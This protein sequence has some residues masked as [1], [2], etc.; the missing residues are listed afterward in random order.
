MTI[1]P[2]PDDFPPFACP[3]HKMALGPRLRCL[4]CDRQYPDVN[5]VPVLI[6]DAN[7]VFAIDDYLSSETAYDGASGYAGHLDQRRGIRQAY[8]RL[9]HRLLETDLAVRSFSIEDAM[10]AVQAARPQ[11][12][13]LVIGAG[14]TRFV[15]RVLYTDVAFGKNVNC[16]ADAHDLPFEDGSFDACFAVAVLEH[17]A[18]PQR[19]VS[20]VARVLKPGG[21]VFAETPFMQPVHMGAYDF[22]RFTF[23][24]HRRL[25]RSFDEVCSGMAGGP[26]T[27]AAQ[28]LRYALTSVSDRASI[29]KWL[30][31][32]S[33]VL[34]IPIRLLER[35]SRRTLS[36]YDSASG[37]YFFGR[38]RPTPISD[39]EMLRF[40]RGG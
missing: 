18:D 35:L 11:A 30:R 6:N 26:A 24:G 25:F 29:R 38:L 7:S 3:V 10:R 5:G 1:E 34:T 8:R 20:E 23:L 13:V 15:G 14:D 33:I 19:C 17:V 37:F 22:T 31:L 39:R 2:L 40:Y 32:A 28:M 21:F 12:N 9:M 4:D 36:A 16:I 27:S